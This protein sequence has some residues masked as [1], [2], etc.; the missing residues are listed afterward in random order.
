MKPFDRQSLSK[1]HLPF[2]MLTAGYI[3]ALFVPKIIREGMFP[4]GLTYSSIARNMAIG[5]GS[6]WQPYF[7]SSFWLPYN[8]GHVFYEHPPLMMGIQSLF[9]RI[10]GDHWFVEKLYCALLLALTLFLIARIWKVVCGTD[11]KAAYFSW[12]PLLL[13]YTMPKVIWAYPNNMLDS[14]MA[15]FCLA[16]VYFSLKALHLGKKPLLYL[17]FGGLFILFAFLTKGPIGLFPLAVPF[18]YFV[19]FR[20]VRFSTF[21][22]YQGTLLVSFLLL[23]SILLLYTP[24]RDFIQ[25]YFNQQ[26][27][28]AITGQRE[29]S[30]DSWVSHL[31]ILGKLL[32]ELLPPLAV[33]IVLALALRLKKIRPAFENKYNL[34]AL[35]FL[36]IGLS[37]SVPI[38]I[39]PKQSSFYLIPCLPYFSLA[40]VSF[41]APTLK[42]A[43]ERFRLSAKASLL[44]NRVLGF[45]VVVVLIYCFSLAGKLRREK[46]VIRDLEKIARVVPAGT[47]I[48]TGQE[49]IQDFITQTYFQ[50]YHQLELAQ[51]TT[52]SYFVVDTEKQ[53]TP[54]FLPEKLRYKRAPIQT[55]RYILYIK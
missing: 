16:S 45:G 14:T 6:L 50:R 12:L 41:A 36:L 48:G 22:L 21:M 52:L 1:L 4:D 11:V 7:S 49:T 46:E 54:A 29:Q 24:A 3:V 25:N 2:Q 42:Q 20:Q 30:A 38:T 10:M 33:S 39:S 27:V 55:E 31:Y 5:K 19:V 35:F 17:T 51:D 53:K 28:N 43:T 47:V 37:G 15:A 34:L 8:T 13:F 23:F 26:V 40:L 9:F 44:L 18:L 32:R